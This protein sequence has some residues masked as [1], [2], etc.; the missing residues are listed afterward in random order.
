MRFSSSTTTDV[1]NFLFMQVEFS[2]LGYFFVN[3][4]RINT[5]F[6][7]GKNILTKRCFVSV[8]KIFAV[9]VFLVGVAMIG[10]SMYITKQIEEGKI[11]IS[12]AERQLKQGS[13]L[14]SINPVTKQIG[15]GITSSADR[16]IARANQDILTYT[17]LAQLLMV[18]GI[19]VVIIGLGMFVFALRTRK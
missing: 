3:C 14:F 18:G 8:K 10:G 11:Q 5:E 1:R 17:N 12:N 7:I 16:K 15:E 13:A 2:V 9:I 19:I 4:S 6:C